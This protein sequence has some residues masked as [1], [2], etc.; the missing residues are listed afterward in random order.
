VVRLSSTCFS[1]L[2]PGGAGLGGV[3]AQVD[4]CA[5]PEVAP[6]HP[7]GRFDLGDVQ[8]GVDQFSRCS[9]LIRLIQ[10][11]GL[12]LGEH[13][14]GFAAHDARKAMMALSGVRSSW[15]MLARKA[16]LPGWPV[17]GGLGQ[18]QLFFGMLAI[19]DIS[20]GFDSAHDVAQRVVQHGCRG[21]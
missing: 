1:S 6:A 20:N 8:D 4:Q 5:D 9:A 2:T 17:R 7:C 19:R 13:A 18:V 10:V 14:F 3:G 16:L 21:I 11:F 15:L 12:F